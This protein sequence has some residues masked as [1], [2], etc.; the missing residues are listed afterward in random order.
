MVHL[1]VSGAGPQRPEASLPGTGQ[2][3]VVIVSGGEKFVA[4]ANSSDE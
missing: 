2:T 4:G 1:S 3:R